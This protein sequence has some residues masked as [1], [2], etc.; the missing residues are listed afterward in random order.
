VIVPAEGFDSCS[1][2]FAV[3]L[4]ANDDGEL[5]AVSLLQGEP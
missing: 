1:H 3:Q 4:F 2:D 5:V